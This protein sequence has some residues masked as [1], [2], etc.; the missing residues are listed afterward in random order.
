MVRGKSQVLSTS[1]RMGLLIQKGEYF[2][3][4]TSQEPF[5]FLLVAESNEDRP[6]GLILGKAEMV[7]LIKW[8]KQTKYTSTCK[9]VWRAGKF[10]FTG[11]PKMSDELPRE[12]KIKDETK[13]KIPND[14]YWWIHRDYMLKSRGWVASLKDRIK[15]RK[16]LGGSGM[17]PAK[18]RRKWLEI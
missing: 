11:M 3:S 7:V 12:W 13:S 8:N 14:K 5:Q 10:S 17:E 2:R 6:N 9:R 4:W 18:K 15:K 1:K 16:N